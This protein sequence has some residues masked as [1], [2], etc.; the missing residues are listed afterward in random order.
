MTQ[1]ARYQI[2]PDASGMASWPSPVR[3]EVIAA[4]AADLAASIDADAA[5][6]W[7]LLPSDTLSVSERQAIYLTACQQLRQ[8][9]LQQIGITK[10]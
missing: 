5:R 8:D 2:R 4:C 7:S 3:P 1:P 10:P 6:R 9:Q